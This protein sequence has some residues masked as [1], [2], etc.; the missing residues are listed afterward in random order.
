LKTEPLQFSDVEF[1]H[2]RQRALV[3]SS[4]KSDNKRSV[5]LPT[6]TLQL[7]RKWVYSVVKKKKEEK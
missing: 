2:R 5:Y 4:G 6:A 1:R 3:A 7:P